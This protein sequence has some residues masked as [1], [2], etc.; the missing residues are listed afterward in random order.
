MQNSQFAL[1][2][3]CYADDSLYIS[4]VQENGVH[5]MFRHWPI[6]NGQQLWYDRLRKRHQKVLSRQRSLRQ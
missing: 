4:A 3:P 1:K 2:N 5:Q 6:D